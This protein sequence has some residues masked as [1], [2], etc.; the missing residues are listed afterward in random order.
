MEE[1]NEFAL[2]K[3]MIERGRKEEKQCSLK[4]N[5]DRSSRPTNIETSEE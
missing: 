2:P 4:W 3:K 1:L 5:N